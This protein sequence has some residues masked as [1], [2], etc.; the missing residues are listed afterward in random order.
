MM[1]PKIPPLLYRMILVTA[2]RLCCWLP[3]HLCE[4]VSGLLSRTE[5]P[6]RRETGLNSLSAL[7]AHQE[8]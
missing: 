4:P 7:L 2:V 5:C 1:S 3:T 6:L 8:L